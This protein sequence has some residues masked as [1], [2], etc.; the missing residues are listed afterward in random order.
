ME[1][2]RL[3]SRRLILCIAIVFLLL[4]IHVRKDSAQ[5]GHNVYLPLITTLAI[6]LPN[7]DFESDP[8]IWTTLPVGT[9]L[10]FTQA[11]LPEGIIP[12]SGTHVAWLGDH[13]STSQSHE[14]EINQVVIAP[15]N[16]P[17]LRFWIQI[18]SNEVCA[19]TKDKLWIFS[20]EE[21]VDMLSICQAQN[22]YTWAQRVIQLPAAAGESIT[23]KFRITTENLGIF[24]PSSEVFFDDFVFA[25][26]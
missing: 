26:H 3:H 22:T 25:T 19:N 1:L 8:A 9:Q 12:H 4:T 16:S 7:G 18:Q 2:R 13:G 15:G 20:N 23:L 14:M 21:L 24:S 17:I 6:P 11:E 10:I 5:I